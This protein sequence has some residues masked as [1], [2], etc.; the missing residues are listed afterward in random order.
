MAQSRKSAATVTIDQ[1]ARLAGV[2]AMSVSNVLNG[3][4]VRPATRD[5]VMHAIGELGYAPNAAARQLARG[6]G[7]TIGVLH[8]NI[9]GAFLS[10]VLVGALDA[11]SRLGATIMLEQV[12]ADLLD[13]GWDAVKA[14]RG[15][16]AN[17]VLVPPGFAEVMSRQPEATEFDFPIMA[18][19]PGEDLATIPSVRIDDF[20]AAREMTELLVSQGHQRIGFIRSSPRYSFSET[21]WAG[22]C[23]ALR[24]HGIELDPTLVVESP[25]PQTATTAAES[26]LRLDRPPTAIFACL[27]ELAAG[28][29]FAARAAGRD[30]PGDLA[31]A[32]FDDTPIAQLVWPPLTTVRQP[33]RE[34]AGI[35]IETLVRQVRGDQGGA[36]QER[37]QTKYLPYEIVE[38]GS[39]AAG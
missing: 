5:A 26:L 7:V 13:R 16:G 34:M 30:V 11:A 21:R 35:A 39:T 2:S 28:A 14:L 25:Q 8:G 37:P 15:R 17:A 36:N 12:D 32:G 19:A 4:Q 22:Y 20:A 24:D 18:L 31:I 23:A 6:A 10:A 38:R 27:D 33:V 9:A 1:V 29:L 3:R